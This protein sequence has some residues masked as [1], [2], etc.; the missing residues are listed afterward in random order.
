MKDILSIFEQKQTRVVLGV[1]FLILLFSAIVVFAQSLQPNFIHNACAG[2]CVADIVFLHSKQGDTQAENSYHAWFNE[3]YI[4]TGCG[5]SQAETGIKFLIDVIADSVGAPGAPTL[6][7]WQGLGALGSICNDTCSDYFHEDGAYAPNVRTSLL[8]HGQGFAQVKVDNTTNMAIHEGDPEGEPNAYSRNFGL[9][10]YLKYSDHPS[11]LVHTQDMPSL[12]FPNWITRGGWDTCAQQYG[13]EDIRCSMLAFFDTPS[14]VFA[15]P[16]FGDGALSNLSGLTSNGQDVRGSAENG[17][18]LLATDD[19]RVT[20]NQGPYTVYQYTWTHNKSQSTYREEVTTRDAHNQSVSIT[21]HEC[22]SVYCG[23]VNDKIDRDIYVFVLDGPQDRM[24]LGDYHVEVDAR[25]F[26]DKDTSDN[27]V[28]YDYSVSG[29]PPTPMPSPTPIDFRAITPQDIGPGIHTDALTSGEAIHLYRLNVSPGTFFVYFELNGPVGTTFN[30]F[31]LY[32]QPPVQS[33]PYL[34]DWEYD[35]WS[36][37]ADTYNAA[38]SYNRPVAGD[39]YIAVIPYRGNGAYTLDIQIT[40]AETSTPEP[41]TTPS[42]TVQPTPLTGGATEQEPNDL[43]EQATQWDINH[44]MQGQLNVKGDEDIF[45]F[46]APQPG[47]YKISLNN[48]PV[49]IAPDIYIHRESLVAASSSTD[50][51]EGESVRMGIDANAGESYYIKIKAS[52]GHTISDQYYTLGMEVIPDPFEP[53][54]TWAESRS[55]E[56]IASPIS[57]YFYELLTGPGDIY[58][59]TIPQTSSSQLLTID[60]LDVPENVEPEMMIYKESLVDAMGLLRAEAGQPLSMML[61]VNPGEKYYLKVNPESRFQT[62]ESLY[63]L[64]PSSIPDPYEPND[65]FADATIW[66]YTNGPIQGYFAEQISGPGD[67]YQ[68]TVP[69]S[70]IERSLTVN[71]VDVSPNIAPEM[72]IYS[73]SHVQI[74]SNLQAEEGQPISLTFD[75][76]PGN[77]YF[78]QVKPESRLMVS[79]QPYTLGVTG[80]ELGGDVEPEEE[81]EGVEQNNQEEVQTGTV[82]LSGVAYRGAGLIGLPLSGVEIWAQIG[83][84]PSQLA[85]NS[86]ALGMYIITL[87]VPDLTSVQVWAQKEGYRFEPASHMW[88]HDSGFGLKVANFVGTETFAGNDQDIEPPPMAGE[89]LS[90]RVYNAGGE[91]VPG[92]MVFVQTGT[93]DAIQVLG[94]TDSDGTY[95]GEVQ[96]PDGIQV[97]VWVEKEGLTF[98]PP[99]HLF[100]HQVGMENPQFDFLLSKP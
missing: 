47:I 58:S 79:I 48:V 66:E 49:N 52:N 29:P 35:C 56:D 15:D 68:I 67:Y 76:Q 69:N 31:T 74:A 43:Y 91:G 9:Y 96:L 12:S 4:H 92:V 84:G 7:C 90:G 82:I 32:N 86:N 23:I 10:T 11:L 63:T 14:S 80:Y 97:R 2:N 59:F 37:D 83:D 1:V 75:V 87:Q 25:V 46:T 22:N 98:T 5:E 77:T 72:V 60:L 73:G 94:P 100:F 41:Q 95:R 3:Y 26:H 21:N 20:I 51:D 42:L 70:S 71:L 44:P 19:A 34:R 40:M 93:S 8:S 99:Y 45:T 27:K 16:T 50:A 62:S 65:L 18:I 13:A 61:D 28:S 30:L 88:V 53:D 81:D 39:Y 17:Y 36:I 64:S 85:G 24:L 6:Q 33:Y 57:G 54:D 38:C 55:W 78:I 89:L